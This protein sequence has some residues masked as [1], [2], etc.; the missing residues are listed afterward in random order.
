MLADRRLLVLERAHSWLGM[1]L[2]IQLSRTSPWTAAGQLL[3]KTPLARFDS[4]L[5]WRVDNFEGLA[6]HEDN[7]F[8]IVSDDNGS[9]LQTTLLVYFELLPTT[10]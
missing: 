10:R 2:V 4:S 8:F 7:R 3:E 6:H 1:S 9:A 5:G